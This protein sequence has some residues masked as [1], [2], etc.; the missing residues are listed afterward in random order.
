MKHVK[1]NMTD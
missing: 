1:D